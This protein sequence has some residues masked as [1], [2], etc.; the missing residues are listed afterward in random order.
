MI[1]KINKIYNGIDCLNYYNKILLILNNIFLLFGIVLFFLVVLYVECFIVY[2]FEIK[3]YI[4]CFK[5]KI[6]LK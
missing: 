6:F 3:Y 4:L 1:Y 2:V 5:F